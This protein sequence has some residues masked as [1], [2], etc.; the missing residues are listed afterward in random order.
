M[1]GQINESLG[2]DLH[3]IPRYNRDDPNVEIELVKREKATS[4][5][6]L[7]ILIAAE[8]WGYNSLDK[9]YDERIRCY[10]TSSRMVAYDN[11]FSREFSLRTI[12]RWERSILTQIMTGC[13]SKEIG[14]NQHKG[15][16]SAIERIEDG[17]P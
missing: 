9:T 11:G 4:K 1:E 13:E 6:N 12:M 2:L 5:E 3:V 14:E 15:T 10:R 8:R 17:H 16:V 7:F